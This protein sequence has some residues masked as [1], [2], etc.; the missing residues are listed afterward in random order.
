MK[1]TIDIADNILIRSRNVARREH[2][3]LRD[4]VE[5][6]LTL[7]IDTKR[8]QKRVPVAPVTFKGKGLSSRF[9]HASW[10][11]IREAAYEGRGT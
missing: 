7:V 6:G 10:E 3:T 4:M 5:E 2:R 11:R 9:A 1:T 8:S